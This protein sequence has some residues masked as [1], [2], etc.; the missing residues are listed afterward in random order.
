[1][2]F[3]LNPVKYISSI[4]GISIEKIVFV[5][6]SS[7]TIEV[8]NM[9]QIIAFDDFSDD[10][11]WTNAINFEEQ[12]INDEERIDLQIVGDMNIPILF[13]KIGSSII[14][15]K[16][17]EFIP[18]NDQIAHKFSTNFFK[19]VNALQDKIY[20]GSPKEK[21]KSFDLLKMVY[22]KEFGKNKQNDISL[23]IYAGPIT[24]STSQSSMILIQSPDG[25]SI[26]SLFDV[27]YTL[28][29]G[30]G[31]L[32]NTLKINAL[33]NYL[34]ASKIKQLGFM[35]IMHHGSKYNWCSGLAAN[36][37]P[38]ISIFSSDPSH[39]SYRHPHSE[40]LHDF[41]PYLPILVNQ[42]NSLQIKYAF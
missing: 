10:V 1:M 39:K 15:N 2:Q 14:V 24:D 16:L 18:Y 22:I 35:Q 6:P 4:P 25:H 5:P 9:D 12:N 26:A 42:K 37:K 19:S 36:F 28:Y 23:F 27:N 40:V 30:D 20:N 7:G 8:S 41:S 29:T 17:F 13:M 32:N 11:D 38:K 33:I 34:N 3:F 31:Y 21:T